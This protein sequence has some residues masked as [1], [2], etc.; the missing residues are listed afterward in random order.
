[1]NFARKATIIVSATLAFGAGGSAFGR[2]TA[3][4]VASRGAHPEIGAQLVDRADL[5]SMGE[6]VAGLGFAA[7]GAVGAI[8]LV[9]RPREQLDPT[10]LEATSAAIGLGFTATTRLCGLNTTSPDPDAV[11]AA[12][13]LA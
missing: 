8:G 5:R 11:S 13:G 7:L 3:D 6:L 9:T 1:M 10:S 2:G 4:M 12:I